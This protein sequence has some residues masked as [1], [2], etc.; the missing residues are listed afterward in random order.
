MPW[1]VSAQA[2]MEAYLARDSSLAVLQL[3]SRWVCLGLS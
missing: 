2:S 3:L 1:G